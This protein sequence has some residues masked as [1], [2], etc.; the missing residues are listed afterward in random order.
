M[1]L[2]FYF[3]DLFIYLKVIVR[4]RKRRTLYL[5]SP[6]LPPKGLQKPRLG[7]AKTGTPSD[8]PPWVEGSQELGHISNEWLRNGAFR[9]QTGAHMECWH[10]K[11][12]MA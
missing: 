7:W 11:E 1:V 5:P 2:F 9:I 4:D 8:P 12:V 6:G 10:C 3:K